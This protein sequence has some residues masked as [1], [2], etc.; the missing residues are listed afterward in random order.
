MIDWLY[1]TLLW[2]GVMIALVLVVRRPVVRLFG[3]KV[4]YSLWALPFVRLILPPVVMPASLAPE[5]SEVSRSGEQVPIIEPA[6]T[7]PIAS[8]YLATVPQQGLSADLLIDPAMLTAVTVA[9]WLGGAAVFLALRFRGYW[10]MRDAMFRDAREAGRVGRV[11]LIETPAATA[12]LAFGARD[13]VV[14]MPP[15]FLA[16]YDREARDLAV[17]H[18]L[19]HHQGRDLLVNMI[20]QPLFALHWFNPLAHFGWQAL[21]RDQEAACDARVVERQP[22]ARRAEYARVIAS[23]AAGPNVALAAPMACPI[24]GEKSIIERLRSLKMSQLSTRRQTAGRALLVAALVAVPLTATVSYAEGQSVEEMFADDVNTP[25]TPP[26]PPTP[27]ANPEAPLPPEPPTPPDIDVDVDI[28]G[29]GTVHRV[30]T[31]TR[32]DDGSVKREDNV[33]V[34][35][36][37]EGLN[38][39]ERREIEIEMREARKEAN[40]ARAEAGR[41]M[42]IALAESA[43]ARAKA[44]QALKEVKLELESEQGGRTVVKMK[45][46]GDDITA[47]ETREDGTNVVMICKS[48]VM[49][50]ALAGL[51]EA[52]A[53]IAKDSEMDAETRAEVLRSL[54]EQIRNWNKRG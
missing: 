11:R 42:R 20:M 29:E 33:F 48:K 4:A 5:I 37:G 34:W 43:N 12:P 49:A 6:L 23:F 38:G 14:A 45:C 32:A 30:V 39:K 44:G 51:K 13:K 16:M 22:E 31:I 35:N 9:L 7:D 3:A 8:G 53:E 24:L 2:T 47:Q 1:D 15:G 54:D 10:R 52:R 18:E 25:P 19:A 46:K 21:R 27:P 36:G 28:E 41:E 50:E 26:V 17:A 40:A